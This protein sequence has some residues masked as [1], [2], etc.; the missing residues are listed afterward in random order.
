V[1]L[2]NNFLTKWPLTC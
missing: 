1:F 2:V